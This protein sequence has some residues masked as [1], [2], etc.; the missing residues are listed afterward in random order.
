MSKLNYLYS[1]KLLSA[2]K[3]G[4]KSIEG[5]SEFFTWTFDIQLMPV[6]DEHILPPMSYI[7][8]VLLVNFTVIIIMES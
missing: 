2:D 6:H 5:L 8:V 7:T 3:K 4:Y 1:E